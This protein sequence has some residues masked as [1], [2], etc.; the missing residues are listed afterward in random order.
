MLP[1]RAP[2]LVHPIV[3]GT[4]IGANTLFGDSTGK[5]CLYLLNR[6]LMASSKDNSNV[7]PNNIIEPTL[8]TLLAEDQREFEEH[9]EQLIKEVKAKYL[10][11]F[12]VD[13]H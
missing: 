9:T 7:S 4:Q 2:P 6:P 1:Q 3:I 11:N 5:M 8:E 10:A 13:R 12:K